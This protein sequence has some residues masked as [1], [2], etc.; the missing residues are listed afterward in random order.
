MSIKLSFGEKDKAI[1]DFLK[2][3]DIKNATLY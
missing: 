1:Y 2:A 3:E